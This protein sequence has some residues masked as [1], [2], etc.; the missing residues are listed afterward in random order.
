MNAGGVPALQLEDI[1]FRYAPERPAVV[2][3]VSISVARGET[4]CILG[5]SGCGK[6][7]LLKI[8]ASLLPAET[9]RV[10]CTGSEVLHPG[11]ERLVVFQDQD[12]LFPWKSV[13]GNIRFAVQRVGGETE[14][15]TEERVRR[16]L[17]EVELSDAADAYPHTLS[18]GMRQRAALARAFAVEPP[19]LLLD[20]PFASVDAPTRERLGSLLLRL[21][22]RHNPAVLFVTHDVDEA[23]RLGD[24]IVVLGLDGRVRLSTARS[25]E[26]RD[27]G[28]TDEFRGKIRR[29]L[30]A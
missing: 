18:G 27:A 17:E 8:A 30:E 4:V 24:R 25:D 22:D 29:A 5:P 21:R 11:P 10:L 13:A 12:Q 16:A 28:G 15:D 6:T 23:I 19:V 7:T 1:T 2:T 14:E 3:A 20:E 9:G 26:G